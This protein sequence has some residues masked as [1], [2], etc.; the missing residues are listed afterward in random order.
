VGRG[1]ASTDSAGFVA[2]RRLAVALGDEIYY[3]TT[4]ADADALVTDNTAIV[5]RLERTDPLF[6]KIVA[7]QCQH[8]NCRVSISAYI[9]DIHSRAFSWHVDKWDNVVIQLQGRKA[10]DLEGEPTRELRPGDA[11]FLPEDLKHRT[12]TLERSIHLS[13]AFFPRDVS[14]D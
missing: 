6:Q 8:A 13:V 10:F 3:P 5:Q 12:R 4:G 9:A 14:T 7:E 11:L 1:F 2:K